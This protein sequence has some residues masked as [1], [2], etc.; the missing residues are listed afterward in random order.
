MIGKR[1]P[2]GVSCWRERFAREPGGEA[3]AAQATVVEPM[4][5]FELLDD[6]SERMREVASQPQ[7]ECV[8]AGL[9]VVENEQSKSGSSS[10]DDKRR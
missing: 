2:A 7:S 9:R 10:S 4:R 6:E 8:I 3:G 1:S 5:S